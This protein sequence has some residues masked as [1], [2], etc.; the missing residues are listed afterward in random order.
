MGPHREK[1]K[2]H[3]RIKVSNFG[4]KV[5]EGTSLQGTW[6][7][8]GKK[9]EKNLVKKPAKRSTGGGVRLTIV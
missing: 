8:T 9:G 4:S 1:T 7:C 2:P 6:D 3:T 5:N